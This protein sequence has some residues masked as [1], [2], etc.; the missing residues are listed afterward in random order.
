V[1]TLK[2][3]SSLESPFHEE[4]FDNKTR[5]CC[6]KNLGFR[7]M[8]KL[9]TPITIERVPSWCVQPQESFPV[10]EFISTL[11]T[12]MKENSKIYIFS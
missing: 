6:L 11:T 10:R 8:T 12:H 3:N 2:I 4:S 1:R 7:S 9:A 5:L